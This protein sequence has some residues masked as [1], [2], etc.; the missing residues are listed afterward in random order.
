M[1]LGVEGES[2]S[3]DADVRDV[4]A[5]YLDSGGEFLVGEVDGTLVA[6]GGLRRVSDATVRLRRMRVEPAWQR[7]GVGR[8][9]LAALEARAAELGFWTIRLDTTGVQVAAQAMYRAAGYAEVARTVEHGHTFILLEKS[10]RP[11]APVEP[12]EARAARALAEDMEF[13]HSSDPDV[14]RLLAVL[15][16]ATPAGGRILEIGT[17]TGVGTGWLVAG[18]GGRRDVEVVSVEVD[19][20]RH[21]RAAAVGWPACV[22]LVLGD[23]ADVVPGAGEFDLV[24]ADCPVGKL[25]R[26]EI[27]LGALRRGGILVLDDMRPPAGPRH[28]AADAQYDAVRRR[29]TGD[30]DLQ[31]VTLDHGSG[32]I[33]AVRRRAS[34]PGTG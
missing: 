20:R 26:F 21:H 19:E 27:S 23:A 25:E 11:D 15:A 7:R 3:W 18:L 34:E 1:A 8:S 2:G 16:A 10:L 9:L 22:G 4:A 29:I 28:G 31:A 24:F 13:I 32:V 6:M 17:G 14:G 30:P 5:A 12:R 33:V